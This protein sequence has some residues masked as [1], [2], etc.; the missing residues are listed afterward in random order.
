L[1]LSLNK[2]NLSVGLQMEQ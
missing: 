1:K 2:L